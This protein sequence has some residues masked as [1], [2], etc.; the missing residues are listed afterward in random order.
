L[1]PHD[2]VES[3]F[4]VAE[5]FG[6]NGI[7]REPRVTIRDVTL[8]KQG[9][10]SWGLLHFVE[11]WAKPLKVNTTS[12]R[13]LML[14]FGDADTR[15]WLGKRIDLYVVAGNFPNGKKTAV[16]IKGSPDINRTF[17]FQVKR[18]GTGKDTYN[19]VPTGSKVVLG[20]GIV[21]FGKKAGHWGKP[22]TDFTPEELE[23]LA[24]DA[25][26]FLSDPKNAK[27]PWVPDVRQNVKEIREHLAAL[28]APAAPEQ[29]PVEEEPEP[30]I[31][32]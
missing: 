28:A 8:E 27:E 16:R 1:N 9:K 22:F 25:E 26:A 7:A 32:L 6:R 17:T 23:R 3:K 30:E 21:R 14:M 18:F 31:P 10:E 5:D 20:P 4:M 11:P 15:D 2:L 19:L 12:K 29:A 13:A 24:V